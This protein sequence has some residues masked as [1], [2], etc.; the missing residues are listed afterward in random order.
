M[1]QK[2]NRMTPDGAQIVDLLITHGVVITVDAQRRIFADG[3][4]A[5]A[6]NRI[7]AVGRSAEVEKAYR[8]RQSIDARGGVVQPGFIDAHVHL[9]QHLGRSTIPDSW[10]DEREHEQWKPYWT[11]I[12]EDEA[13]CSAMLACMEMARNGT[14]TFCECGGRFRAELN[15]SV[16]L[17]VGLRGMVAERCR[18]VPQYA[19]IPTGD[20]DDCLRQLE[21]Q[22]QALPKT[23][24]GRVWACVGISG[25][26]SG[27]DRL[28]IGAKQIADRAGVIMDMHQSFGPGDTARYKQHTGNKTAVEHFAGLGILGPNL[29]LVHMIYT[30]EAE[31]PLLAQS[32]TSV[33][34]C[35]GA[36]L[37][38]GMGVSRV[39]RFPEM[40]A[41]GVNVG[42]GS[43]SG[44]YS[45]FFDIGRQAYLAATIHREARGQMPTVSAEQAV[46]MATINGARALG[47]ADEIGSLEAGKKADIVIHS[48][49]RPEW[50]PG[51][52]V[53]NSLV[54]GAQSVAVDTVIIDGAV[55]L[56]GGSFVHLDEWEQYRRIDAAARSLY[57][58]MGFKILNRW[59]VVQ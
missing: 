12:N 32:G 49:R 42:L 47:L 55:I 45:D 46:E 43:D 13:Y 37:R 59:P 22:V 31:I 23:P 39:G 52:H 48:Y 15:A 54:Y 30:E 20:T 11:T 26:G 16:A 33:I 18:D 3:A 9:S 36:S 24:D 29:K 38:V 5:V 41:A 7:V 8:A 1:E 19:D 57:A 53:L 2:T 10:P 25:M 35:P 58:R 51:Q 6:G 56:Q 50:R 17:D 40:L 14:T 27:T 21:R 4:L 28:L 44:N 34:H